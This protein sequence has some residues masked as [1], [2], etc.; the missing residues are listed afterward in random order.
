MVN[1]PYVVHETHLGH[2]PRF[3]G[4]GC[5]H[6]YQVDDGWVIDIDCGEYN[7]S[8][9]EW[10]LEFQPDL[11]VSQIPEYYDSSQKEIQIASHSHLVFVRDPARYMHFKMRWYSEYEYVVWRDKHHNGKTLHD[12]IWYMDRSPELWVDCDIPYRIRWD[13]DY[14]F[15]KGEEA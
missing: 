13:R 7:E 5:A 11:W 2:D 6:D 15:Y 14:E 3:T 9:I 10:L 12:F 1:V 8:V 4:I